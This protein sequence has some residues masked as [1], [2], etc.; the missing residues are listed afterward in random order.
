MTVRF[1]RACSSDIHMQMPHRSQTHHSRRA[2][3]RLIRLTVLV[4][5]PLVAACAALGSRTPSAQNSITGNT[6]PEWLS[7]ELGCDRTQMDYRWNHERYGSTT[8]TD[9]ACVVLG[10]WG[11]PTFSGINHFF[12]AGTARD[13][14]LA[15]AELDWRTNTSGAEVRIRAYKVSP[16]YGRPTSNYFKIDR[17]PNSTALPDTSH[18]GVIAGSVFDTLGYQLHRP[19]RVCAQRY[20][21][22]KPAPE[23]LGCTTTS[24]AGT[25]RLDALPLGSVNLN[26]ACETTRIFERQIQPTFTAVAAAKPGTI[27]MLMN[28]TGCDDRPVRTISRVFRGF[29]S[30]GFEMNDF[31]PCSDDSWGLASDTTGNGNGTQATR[32]WVTALPERGTNLWPKSKRLEARRIAGGYIS[33]VEWRGTITGPGHYGHLGGAPFKIAVDSVIKMRAPSAKDCK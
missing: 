26:V 4:L 7:H 14:E 12:D 3:S 9:S 1:V 20:L 32:A 31:S 33:Y 19:V 24:V 18:T 6:A 22:A 25:F 23:M 30:S 27:I 15:Q 17:P 21:A 13:T 29:W 10:R 16:G 8:D 28:T 11:K 2:V 5:T